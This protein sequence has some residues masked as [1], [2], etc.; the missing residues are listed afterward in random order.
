[1]SYGNK[2]GNLWVITLY[3][4]IIFDDEP[5]MFSMMAFYLK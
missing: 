2:L 1:V 3:S 5:L 4:R